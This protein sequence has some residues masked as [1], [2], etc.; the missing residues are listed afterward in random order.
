MKNNDIITENRQNQNKQD[1]NKQTQNKQTQNKPGNEGNKELSEK[2][3]LAQKYAHIKGWGID[4]D[5]RNE[6]NYPMKKYTGDD[7]NRLNYE[8]PPMQESDIEVLH[9]IERPG[10]S[11]VYGTSVP[12]SGL[13]G[14]L[15]RLAFRFSESS[16]YHWLPLILADRVN[17]VEGVFHDLSR[18]KVP[19][20]FAELGGKAEWKHNRKGFAAKVFT[21]AV[22]TTAAIIYFSRKRKLSKT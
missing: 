17:A 6:P 7:H 4:A 22:I 12:P 16:Y 9:S 10:L 13:S 21:G 14:L 19:N 18:L 3:K 11:A 2:D 1:Q 15:R 20:V 8:K 5:P